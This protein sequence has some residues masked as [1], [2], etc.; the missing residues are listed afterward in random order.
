M[1]KNGDLNLVS[2][3][4]DISES[5]ERLS[6]TDV[7]SQSIIEKEEDSEVACTKPE[8]IEGTLVYKGN[9]KVRKKPA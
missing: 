1:V 4:L 2:A 9:S 5:E 7:I 6:K 3:Q 8:H